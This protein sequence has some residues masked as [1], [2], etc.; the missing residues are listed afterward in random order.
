MPL[1]L[2]R[3]ATTQTMK[4]KNIIPLILT[5]ILF[6]C[7][8][9]TRSQQNESSGSTEDEKMDTTETPVPESVVELVENN[10]AVQ[11]SFEEF[12]LEIDSFEVWD[13]HGILSEKQKDTAKVHLELGETIEGK[14]LR[15]KSLTDGVLKV[16]QRFESSVTVMNE[17][18]H[19]DLI[20]WKHYDSEWK[21]LKIEGG[22]FLTDTYSKEDWEKFIEVDMGE[23][24]EAVR[25]ECGEPW[26]ELVK[27]AKS[28]TE[29]PYG[30]STSRVFL[31]IE[32]YN[33]N[34]KTTT[35]RIISFAIPMGC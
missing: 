17:G 27:E 12:I 19:C 33:P 1:N 8:E 29:Y 3:I 26:A 22:E 21:E 13:D 18:P 20:N 24:L 14:T 7:S 6:S 15:I 9:N 32:C 4:L 31:K 2:L 30:V 5:V 35:E 28:P 25:S 34:D 10:S 11:V 16:Y 23:L